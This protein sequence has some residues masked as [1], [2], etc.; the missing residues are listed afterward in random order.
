LK[1]IV[2]SLPSPAKAKPAKL[3]K[4]LNQHWN[5]RRTAKIAKNGHWPAERNANAWIGLFKEG[6]HPQSNR[7]PN[8]DEAAEQIPP[9]PRDSGSQANETVDSLDSTKHRGTRQKT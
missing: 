3:S 9:R 2:N 8:A 5:W 4:R 6:N 1:G 7:D